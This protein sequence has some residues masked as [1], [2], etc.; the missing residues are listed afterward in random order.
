MN[1]EEKKLKYLSDHGWKPVTYLA[2][3]RTDIVWRFQKNN[4]FDQ[5]EST[6]TMLEISRMGFGSLVRHCEYIEKRLDNDLK[7]MEKWKLIE[8]K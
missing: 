4:Q 1:T 5:L 6:L 3:S 2:R 7:R 8:A